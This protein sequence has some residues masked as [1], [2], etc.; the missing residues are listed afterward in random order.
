M[1]C[2]LV[3][4]RQNK[5]FLN[6][7]HFWVS[8]LNREYLEDYELKENAEYERL[9][10]KRIKKGK[11]CFEKDRYP[12]NERFIKI[13]E[14]VAFSTLAAAAGG[15]FWAQIP[16]CGSLILML[17]PYPVKIFEKCL[18]KIS[19]IP[20]IVDFI[21]ETGRLQIALSKNPL[22]YEGLDYLDPFFVELKP[23]VYYRLSPHLLGDY[24]DFEKACVTFDTLSQVKFY[25]YLKEISQINSTRM[26]SIFDML[27]GKCLTTFAMLKLCRYQIIEDIENLMID[28]PKEAVDLLITC[29]L[30]I[31]GP[32]GDLRSSLRFVAMQDIEKVEN[33][34]IIC[35]PQ[36]IEFPCEIGKFLIKKLTYAPLGLDACKEL[37][38]HYDAYD[39]RKVLRALNK[40]IVENHH[41]IVNKSEKELSE[42]L[43]NVWNDKTIPRRV[44]GLQIGI[45]LL[46]AAIGS[47]AAGPIGTMGGFLAGLGLN[48]AHKL[49]DLET[50]GLSESLA[51][52]KTKSYQ[53]NIYDFQQKYKYK[54]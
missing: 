32:M 46:M 7:F 36:E 28:N 40:A 26:K 1:Y 10:E 5:V 30:F 20:K 35:R 3:H 21:K 38:Y 51:K 47:V 41:E 2:L 12:P 52:L 8:I 33:L 45:P 43:D 34:P 18:F 29:M 49:I 24:E 15:S 4:K 48:V 54:L 42:I 27:I 17:P 53:V 25:N 16:F 11:F 39:L 44:K 31:T 9:V 50:Q 37:M 19:E 22:A 13:Q 6:N 14:P 23:P